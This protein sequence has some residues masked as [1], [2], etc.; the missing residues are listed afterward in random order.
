MRFLPLLTVLFMA[1]SA[2]PAL[3]TTSLKSA[4]SSLKESPLSLTYALVGESARDD[5]SEVKGANLYHDFLIS[6]KITD[7]DDLRLTPE[8]GQQYRSDGFV[9]DQYKRGVT[10]SYEGAELRYRRKKLLTQADHLV[11]VEF[12][13]RYFYFNDKTT[14]YGLASTRFYID[15]SFSER[16]SL[17]SV[18]RYDTDHLTSSNI[19]ERQGRLRVQ[20][21]P[22][23]SFDDQ[24]S[25]GLI[26][27]YTHQDFKHK[28]RDNSDLL[29]LIPNLSYAFGGGTQSLGAAV[30]IKALEGNDKSTFVRHSEDS[31][32]YE[33]SYTLSVF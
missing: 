30:Y 5:N 18:V 11:D 21:A 16:F 8:L 33:L 22:T 26:V 6:Y 4:W 10:S 1:T 15:R 31:I 13:Q 27:R 32:G 29:D 2:Y 25:G 3:S 23:W 12:Q 28:A 19:P 9:K 24:L 7:K 14:S 17:K 20:T